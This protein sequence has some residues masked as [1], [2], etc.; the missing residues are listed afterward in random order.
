MPTPKT[1]CTELSVGFGLLGRDPLEVAA[2]EVVSLWAD[3]LSI[4]KFSEYKREFAK[5]EV[6]YRKFYAIGVNL[7]RSHY[8]FKSTRATNVRWEGP[9]Q[10]ARSVSMAKD[11]I[12]ANTPVSV[13]AK[14]SVVFN[15]SPHVLFISVPSG[16][17]SPTRS[18]NWY[19]TV[20]ENPY[21]NFYAFAR[22]ACY[23]DLPDSIA[24]YHSSVHKARRRKFQ[25]A[26]ADLA[27]IEADQLK[28]LYIVFCYEAAQKSAEIFTDA[29]NRSFAS[30]LKNA[31]SENIIR[32][33][34]RLSDSEYVLCGLDSKVDFGITVPDITTWKRTWALKQ[35][36]AQPDF[37][38]EQSV[39]NFALIVGEK[40]KR[41][42]FPLPFHAEIRWSHGKFEGNP[43]AKLYKD[44]AWTDVPFLPQIYRQEAVTR[45]QLIGTGGFGT[46]YKAIFRKT[47]QVV[48][49]KE[50]D[51]SKLNFS[52]EESHE[53]RKRFEREVKIQHK[54]DHP[55]ILPIL[56]YDLEAS[57]PWFAMPLAHGSVADIVDELR[58]NTRK[59]NEIFQQVL[60]GIKYAHRNGVIHRD[61]KPENILIFEGQSIRIGDFGLGKQLGAG[62]PDNLLTHT[63]NNSLGSMAYAAPEQLESFRDAD[64]CADI[65]ALGKTLLHMLTGKVPVSL[66]TVNQIDECYREFISHCIQENPDHRFQSVTEVINAFDSILNSMG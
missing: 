65:Y 3:T 47:G 52:P 30:S 50:L 37:S 44:F 60:N 8:L 20:A 49:V 39:V 55:N 31:V 34:F 13:K 27:P 40:G 14:S 29:L 22:N 19:L 63:S 18:E 17:P 42:D 43:E 9:Q 15:L 7:R 36:T 16:M 56:D 35:I 25:K 26:I 41:N 32:H 23:P 57:T 46:V 45:L 48:A 58:G 6:F 21:Q 12:F 62:D 33:F 51:I 53:A 61:L 38:R 10:Q 64:Y 54:L 5:K 28:H 2:E 11:I 59:I 4:K 1:E 24:D 66:S